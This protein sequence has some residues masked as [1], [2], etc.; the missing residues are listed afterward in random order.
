MDP[1]SLELVVG[2]PEPCCGTVRCQH[3]SIRHRNHTGWLVDGKVSISHYASNS[4]S[5]LVAMSHE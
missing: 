1:K 3:T 4:K 5:V 2:D